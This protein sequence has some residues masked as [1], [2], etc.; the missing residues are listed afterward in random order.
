MTKYVIRKTLVGNDKNPAFN[1]EESIYTHGKDYFLVA[2]EGS[3]TRRNGLQF[4]NAVIMAKYVG[5]SRKQDAVRIAKK[6]KEEFSEIYWDLKKLEVVEYTYFR[7]G[8]YCESVVWKE[9]Y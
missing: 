2:A 4:N 1:G 8:G 3:H 5:Y 9:T 6:R 7:E